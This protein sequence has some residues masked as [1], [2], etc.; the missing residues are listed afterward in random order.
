MMNFSQEIV[1]HLSLLKTELKHYFP[2]VTCCAYIT[3]SFSVDPAD[4][5]VGIG[6]QEALIDTQ[7]EKTAKAKHKECCPINFW[8]S[9]ASSYPK[10]AHR[11]VLQLL[12]FLSTSDA[13][14][15]RLFALHRH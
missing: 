13:N 3:N 10:L 6:E 4:L 8:V 7:S 9:M 14:L 2:E 12:I 11:A 15:Y 1:H 5:S